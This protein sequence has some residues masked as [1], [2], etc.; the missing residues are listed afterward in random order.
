MHTHVTRLVSYINNFCSDKV[1]FKE[2]NEENT[3]LD[4]V[5]LIINRDKDRKCFTQRKNV[6]VIAV[7][8]FIENK[9][10]KKKSRQFE[11]H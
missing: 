5:S 3:Q 6:H 7:L 2:K 9:T 10:T 11:L 1:I 4:Y 8:E